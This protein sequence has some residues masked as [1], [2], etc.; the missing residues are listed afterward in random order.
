[1]WLVNQGLG[2]TIR[3]YPWTLTTFAW[4]P[5]LALG[6]IL[7]MLLASVKPKLSQQGLTGYGVWLATS[8]VAGFGVYE[9]VIW[10]ACIVL[11]GCDS[12]TPPILWGIFQGNATWAIALIGIHSV[13][14]WQTLQL[15]KRHAN[16]ISTQNHLDAP[17]RSV[18]P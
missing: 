3:H 5:V 12:F 7:V 2:F 13:L 10:L 6:A 1:M 8:L 18:R 15:S 4:G 16:G 17:I 14:V 11:G 9:L